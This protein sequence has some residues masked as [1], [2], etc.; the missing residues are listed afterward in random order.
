MQSAGQ[1]A[2][3]AEPAAG[4][5][6]TGALRSGKGNTLFIQFFVLFSIMGIGVLAGKYGGLDSVRNDGIGNLLLQ[7]VMPALLLNSVLSLEIGE[8]VLADFLGM[9]GLSLGWFVLFAVLAHLYVRVNR[10]PRSFGNMVEISLDSTN[11]AFMGFPIA[12]AF[13]GEKGLVFMVAHNLVMNVFMFSYGV[14]KLRR[15]GAGAEEIQRRTPLSVLREILN[16]NVL[17]IFLGLFLLLSGLSIHV[18]EAILKMLGMVGGM[19][20][21]LSMIYIGA[22]LAG[23]R[24]AG[25][26]HDR[27]VVW[28]S[29]VRLTV[30]PALVL[31][32]CLLL[33]VPGEM[34]QILLLASMLPTAAV[35]PVLTGTFAPNEKEEATKIVLFSTLLSLGTTPLSVYLA[36]L[37]F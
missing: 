15:A 10:Y 28:A 23:A 27:P 19:A 3:E 36:H 18:P 5:R 9:V 21:P 4:R 24:F 11:N 37:F 26:S 1:P 6:T 2:A 35:V 33:P 7:V 13:F 12:I 25:I 22:I 31:G 16:A 29:I 14:Y 8:R 30:F 32:L 34:A 17:A 20:T